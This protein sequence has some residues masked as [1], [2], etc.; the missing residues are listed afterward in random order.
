[1]VKDP[2]I[3]EIEELD[4]DER[5]QFLKLRS[6]AQRNEILLLW[7]ETISIED[8]GKIAFPYRNT[9]TDAW[10]GNPV[11]GVPSLG[12]IFNIEP[13]S[14]PVRVQMGYR[15]NKRHYITIDKKTPMTAEM[16]LAAMCQWGCLSKIRSQ[17]GGLIESNT[18]KAK[19]KSSPKKRR[20]K[21]QRAEL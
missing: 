13:V 4:P 10:L 2:I 12:R 17:R 20:D 5:N 3:V 6:D 14:E 16:A 8:Y 11:R 9:I 21:P 15:G 1:M 7:A 18:S 19:K